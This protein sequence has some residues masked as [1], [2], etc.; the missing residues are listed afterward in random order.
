MWHDQELTAYQEPR[1]PGQVLSEHTGDLWAPFSLW[2]NA[3]FTQQY[4]PRQPHSGY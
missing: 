2:A 3:V 4:L 1:A